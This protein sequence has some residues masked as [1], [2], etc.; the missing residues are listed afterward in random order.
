[1]DFVRTAPVRNYELC[2]KNRTIRLDFSQAEAD[3]AF[4]NFG[5]RPVEDDSSGRPAGPLLNKMF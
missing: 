5:A 3:H 1:M 4:R 2:L